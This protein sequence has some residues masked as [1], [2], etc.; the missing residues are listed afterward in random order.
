MSCRP[1]LHLGRPLAPLFRT[2]ELSLFT[3]SGQPSFTLSTREAKCMNHIFVQ[4]LTVIVLVCGRHHA[5]A[6]ISV[7]THPLSPKTLSAPEPSRSHRDRSVGHACGDSRSHL[8]QCRR[9]SSRTRPKLSRIS[10]PMADRRRTVLG[11]SWRPWGERKLLCHP[12]TET[13]VLHK[14]VHLVNCQLQFAPQIPDDEEFP[15]VVE[16]SFHWNRRDDVFD[17]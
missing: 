10:W 15:A 8:R 6:L 1:T 5:P 4:G 16:G 9:S 12:N 11:D 2:K 17:R 7:Q 3:G 14:Q 13:P